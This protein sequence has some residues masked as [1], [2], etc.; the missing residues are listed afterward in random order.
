LWK[1]TALTHSTWS[2]PGLLHVVFERC[3][4]YRAQTGFSR[5]D[6]HNSSLEA[7]LNISHMERINTMLLSRTA[8]RGQ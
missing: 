8:F 7:F 5:R 4:I 1:N 6:R 3:R 2:L